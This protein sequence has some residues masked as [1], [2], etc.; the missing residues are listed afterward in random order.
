MLY[1]IAELIIVCLI[2]SWIF[3]QIKLPGFVGILVVGVVFGPYV[4]GLIEPE[5]LEISSELRL[6]GLVVILLRAGFE[7]NKQTLKKVGRTALILSIIPTVFEIGVIT[8][9]APKLLNISYFEAAILGTIL[10]AVS[11]AVVVLMMIDLINKRKGTKKGIPTLMI[12]TASLNDVFVILVYSI[13]I[14]IYT[15]TQANLI[16]EIAGIPISIILSVFVGVLI[17]FALIKLFDK[18]NTRA[19]RDDN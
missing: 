13:F 17:G 16:W 19:T 10:G 3:K 1:S 6:A 4:L 11:P 5:L 2:V 14:G 12:T 15:G 8:L 18:I 9:I 7:I